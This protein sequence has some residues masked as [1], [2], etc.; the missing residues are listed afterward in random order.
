MFILVALKRGKEADKEAEKSTTSA[1]AT[2]TSSWECGYPPAPRLHKIHMAVRTCLETV[3]RA[4]YPIMGKVASG[5]REESRY[6]Y[7]TA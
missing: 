2:F 3:G 7:V 1:G 4:V 6:N 5:L